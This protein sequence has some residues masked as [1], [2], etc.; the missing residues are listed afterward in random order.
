MTTIESLALGGRGWESGR[1]QRAAD[2][3]LW[4]VDCGLRKDLVMH[5]L[6]G[7]DNVEH[8]LEYV[9]NIHGI[10]FINDSK[11]TNLN[12]T[13][14]ALQ[15]M[16]K[17]V[18]WIAGGQDKGNDW[19]M[20][21]PIVIKKVKSIILLALDNRKLVHSL[22]L[23]LDSNSRSTINDKPWAEQR[24]LTTIFHATSM[25]EAVQYAYNIAKKG[26]VVL[27]SP[28]CPSYDLFQDYEDRGR[29]FKNIVKN[30]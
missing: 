7:S 8:R 14:W 9:A 11:A 28:A 21:K 12:S 29:Q 15:T 10:E 25:A 30:L 24:S 27:L 22:S 16:S 23:I 5:S 26:D 3:A 4:S 17:P 2:C 6:T 1:P 13:W 20:L 19:N 18:I